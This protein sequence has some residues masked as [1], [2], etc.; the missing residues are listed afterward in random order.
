[1]MKR[2][3]CIL[4]SLMMLT[5]ASFALAE[6]AAVETA[7]EETAVVEPAAEETI[8]PV[9]LV[10]V[11]GEEIWSNSD[12]LQMIL[13]YYLDVA[14]SNGYDITDQGML[15]TINWYSLQYTMRTTVLRQKAAE[16]GLDQLTD[17]EK[18]EMEA[19]GKEQWAA[20]ID[21][22]ISSTGAITDTATDDEKAAARADAEAELLK[23]GYTEEMMI[24]QYTEEASEQLLT[25]RLKAYLTADKT[26][27][28]EEVQAYFDDLVKDDKESY[29]NDVGSYEFYSQYYGQPSYYTPE[30]Y[31]GVTNIL[32]K[33]DDELM[34]TWKDLSARLEEQ[35]SDAQAETVA[36][37]ETAADAEPTAEPEPTE[38]PVTEEMVKAAEQAIL[39]S[40]RPTVDEIMAKLA[41]G[42]SFDDLI[43]EYG[44]DPGMANDA[45]RAEGYAVHKD[46]IL[47]DPAFTEAAMALEKIGD[48]GEPVVGQYGVHILHYLRDIPGGAVELTDEMKEEF[49]STLLNEI[50]NEALN[51]A[52]DQWMEEGNIVYTEAGEDWKLSDPAPAATEE[53]P[54]EETS[55]AAEETANP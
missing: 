37:A 14:E 15:D 43:K 52:L 28:D 25:D 42:T 54:A 22:Y 6:D 3:F 5:A 29:E 13:S 19:A 26:V 1:M 33:V 10:T 18:A 27:T 44:Q 31:R 7:A 12:Y 47:W 35:K 53:A 16:L 39:D 40:V 8:E 23:Y 32:L 48:V 46:S 17:E 41:G 49:R 9:L 24:S 38:E 30:G 11:N 36:P 4:L 21:Y 55:E 45:T 50:Q 20:L 2:L 34:N 51:S